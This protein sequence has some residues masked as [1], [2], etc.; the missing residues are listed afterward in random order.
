MV[1]TQRRKVERNYYPASYQQGIAARITYAF[2]NRYLFEGNL[3]FN[4]SEQFARNRQYGLFPS[5]AMGYNLH[6]EKFFEP[7]RKIFSS[8]KLRGSIGQVGSD[9]A[10]D[11]W[12]FTSS[13]VTGDAGWNY[14]PGVPSNV[15]PSRISIIEERAANINVGWE[16]ATKYDLGIEI[17]FLP[18][19]MFTLT[20]DFF[21]ERRTNILQEPKNISSLAGQRAKA[22]NIGEVLAKGYEIELRFQHRT[23]SG[24]HFFAKGAISFADNRIISIGEVS[25]M[26]SYQ[27]QA[28]KRIG[29]YIAYRHTGW[30][31]DADV[32]MTSA[33]AGG[34]QLMGLGDTEWIDFNGDG[35][36]DDFDRVPYGYSPKAP[37]YNYSFSAGLT[38][39]NFEFDFLFQ[40]ASH[41]SK[42]VVDAFAWPMHR[43]SNQVFDYQ[44]DVWSPDNRDARYPAYHFDAIRNGHNG[45]T[46]GGIR[47][48]AI[49]DA[50]YL[51]LKT[52]NFGYNISEKACK[53]IGLDALKVYIR[54]NNLFTWAPD[55]PLGD[56]EAY[57]IRNGVSDGDLTFGYYPITRNFML[58]LQLSF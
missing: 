44:M 58:G 30:I 52:I 41:I 19:E 32:Q 50:S 34:S 26:P 11:R 20:M 15:G 3:G 31:Q 29:Q 39:K 25:G 2:D 10:N 54:G 28:G 12:L 22:Q 24:W 27:M 4:G 1:V 38:Y 9:A 43:L 18:R 17:G 7:L 55:Y 35:V 8:V 37:L 14:T 23:A 53:K 49:Y 48:V 5:V 21:R 13:Y 16:I 56:P 46:D 33:R 51:R 57:D 42:R 36:I 47:D 45:I 40:A 6:N